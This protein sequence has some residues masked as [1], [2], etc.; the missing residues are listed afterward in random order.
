MSEFEDDPVVDAFSPAYAP[1][2]AVT[3]WQTDAALIR[4][5][6]RLECACSSP[7]PHLICRGCAAKEALERLCVLVARQDTALTAIHLMGQQARKD[8]RAWRIGELAR[9]TLSKVDSRC[10]V[11]RGGD[12]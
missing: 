9:V 1:P 7:N 5:S 11:A 4:H 10:A 12:E 3:G 6:T 8:S 2:A